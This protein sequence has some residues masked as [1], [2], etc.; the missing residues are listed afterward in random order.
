MSREPIVEL[1]NYMQSIGLAAAVSWK[2][3]TT[4]PTH[5]P[6]WKSVCKSAY[7]FSCAPPTNQL[8]VSGKEYGVGTG[9]HKHHARNAAAAIALPAFRAESQG[10]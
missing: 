7:S 6:E 3:T 9:T 2:D 1:N 8:S 5:S 4:G 10:G